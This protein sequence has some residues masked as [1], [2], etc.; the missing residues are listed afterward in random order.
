VTDDYTNLP[1]GASTETTTDSRL[2]EAAQD[3]RNPVVHIGRH[4]RPLIIGLIAAVL[5]ILVGISATFD[6]SRASLQRLLFPGTTSV[7][8][9]ATATPRPTTIPTPTLAPIPPGDDWSQYRFDLQ[10]TG[11][12]PEDD[13]TIDN[14]SQLALHWT[15][16]TSAAFESTPAVVDGVVYVTNG[17]SLYAFNLRTSAQLWRF[18]ARPQKVAT[19]SSSVAVDAALHLAFYGNPDARVYAVDTRTGD[20]VWVDQLSTAPGAYVWSSPLLLNGKVYFGVASHDDNPCVRG[21]IYALD[22]TTGSTA[23][24][25]YTVPANAQGGTV[26]SSIIANTNLHELIATTGNPCPEGPSFNESDSILGIDRD[27]GKTSWQY[28][29][30]AYDNCDCDFGEGAVDVVYQGQEYIMAGNKYGSVFALTRS[31]SGG[32]PHLAWSQRISSSG[33]LEQGGIFEPPTYGA[34]LVFVAGGPTLDGACARGGLWAFKVQTGNEVWRA[35]TSGQV[36]G[37]AALTNGVLI[38]P[39]QNKLVAYEASTG[40]VLETLK[41]PGSTWGGVSISHGFVLDGTVSNTLYCY[42]LP[43]KATTDGTDG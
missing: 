2:Q 7:Q 11:S 35:C 13:L 28:Q 1:P 29:A 15:V 43:P 34:G 6:L 38:V 36:V 4:R 27:T 19:V 37:P 33:F 39:Q 20:E 26:W 3:S 30:L 40:Q 32:T 12:N 8:H 25:H 41:Q 16:R 23:W 14:V 31:P 5:V 24:V 17:N 21:A 18:D 10:G 22:E 42:A 9:A